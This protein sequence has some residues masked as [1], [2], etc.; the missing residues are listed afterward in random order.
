MPRDGTKEGRLTVC[1]TAMAP[2]TTMKEGNIAGIGSTVRCT[3]EEL[4]TMLTAES[5]TKANG[6]A[7]L[8]MGQAFSTTKPHEK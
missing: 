2:F 1:G 7:I 6:P 3:V 5:P 8:S 4:S